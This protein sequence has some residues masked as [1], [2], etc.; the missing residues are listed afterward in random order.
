VTGDTKV[1]P[2]SLPRTYLRVREALE[3]SEAA[4]RRGRRR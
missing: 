4:R 1:L 3:S 2:E